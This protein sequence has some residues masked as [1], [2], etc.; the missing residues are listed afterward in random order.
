LRSVCNPGFPAIKVEDPTL[1][2]SLSAN[3]SPLA[4]RDGKFCTARQIHERLIKEQKPN[5][6][7][8]I[9]ANEGGSGFIVCGRGELHLAILIETLRREGY[10][11]Q[12]EN[13]KSF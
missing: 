7:L 9:E 8:K 10:E 4:G 2:I 12:L 1:K 5:I 13:R 6:G 3:T 11:M